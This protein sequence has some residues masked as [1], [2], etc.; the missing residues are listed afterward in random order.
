MNK[1]KYYIV[2][3]LVIFLIFGNTSVSAAKE[4]ELAIAESAKCFDYYNFGSVIADV[5]AL[6][7]RVSNGMEAQFKGSIKNNNSYPVVDASVYVKIFRTESDAAQFQKNGHSIVDQFYVVKGISLKANESIPLQFAWNVPAFAAKG[8]YFVAT[9]VVSD[10]KYNM[11]GLSFTDDIVGSSSRFEVAGEN[12]LSIYI[13]KNTVK[14]DGDNHL[15]AAFIP[16]VSK[17]DPVTVSY[18]IKNDTKT[19]QTVSVNYTLYTWDALRQENKLAQKKDSV[20]IPAKSVKRLEYTVSEDADPVYYLVIDAV[21]KDSH[22]IIDVRFTRE[23]IEKGRINFPGVNTYPFVRGEKTTVFS[24]MHNSGQGEKIDD[25]MMDIK[26]YDK[27]GK[28]IHESYYKGI[29]TGAMMAVK[30]DFIPNKDYTEFSVEASLYNNGKLVDQST[31][32]YKCSELYSGKCESELGE[33][34]FIYIIAGIL[35]VLI[36]LSLILVRHHLKSRQGMAALFFAIAMAGIY[37]GVLLTQDYTYS[38]AQVVI[39]T[40]GVVWNKAYGDIFQGGTVNIDTLNVTVA[41][42]AVIKNASDKNKILP[43]GTNVP[44]GTKLKFENTP[45]RN[46]NVFWFVTGNAEDSPYGYWNASP[47]CSPQ[48]KVLEDADTDKLYFPVYIVHPKVEITQTGT[49]GLSARNSDGSYTVTSP[50]TIVPVYTFKPTSGI[51]RVLTEPVIDLS[52]KNPGRPT[53][54]GSGRSGSMDDNERTG[55]GTVVMPCT[56]QG[57]YSF[58]VPTQTIILNVNAIDEDDN[59]NK[60]SDPIV[61]ISGESCIIEGGTLESIVS[62]VSSDPENDKVY[63]TV[64][65]D[66]TEFR[67]PGA[68]EVDS[69]SI[70]YLSKI[71]STP[72][73][74]TIRIR[75]TDI[76]GATSDWSIYTL[77]VG[78]CPPDIKPLVSSCK[79]MGDVELGTKSNPEFVTTGG[80]APYS[81]T[82]SQKVFNVLGAVT[83]DVSVKDSSVPPLQTNVMCKANVIAPANNNNEGGISNGGNNPGPG[84]PVIPAKPSDVGLL[85][86]SRNTNLPSTIY[87]PNIPTRY[88][89]HIAVLDG[90]FRL[91]WNMNEIDTGYSCSAG[92]SSGNWNAW[93]SLSHDILK[94]GG[95]LPMTAKSLGQYTFTLNCTG[96]GL[97]DKISEVTLKVVEKNANIEEF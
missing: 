7:E 68:G 81:Y 53:G 93:T 47:D 63:Y 31:M 56:E 89:T 54:G 94:I 18:Q 79:D 22:S 71:W 61:T 13:D 92:V 96:N 45:F 8:E 26:V 40:N 29:L 80:K 75:A 62:F 69:G 42:G 9:Y 84:D 74:H 87:E 41:Y 6:N 44:V 2:I 60:P 16:K 14:V 10:E 49:A 72:G 88:K 28:T 59:N 25:A 36:L 70:Q 17:S 77:D 12:G 55:S 57:R 86:G 85:I 58:S 30:S 97:P 66:G 73:K 91:R 5:K 3:S 15:F 35:L 38:S 50:G 64:D 67:I 19:E 90:I 4:K 1:I 46:E 65:I 43:N 33:T 82:P 51:G 27:N 39:P 23:G 52:G 24:C 95:I 21:Y 20:I 37:Q 76:K 83:W 48:D 32:Q 11:S 34:M 78:I